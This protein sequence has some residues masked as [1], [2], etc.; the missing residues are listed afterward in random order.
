VHN[1]S[2]RST[3]Y[4]YALLALI[5][6]PV[7][8]HFVSPN[9]MTRWATAAAIVENRTFEI[10]SLLPLLG[11]NAFEDASEVGGR[12]YSNKAP[13]A[14]LIGL[15]AYAVARLITGP[16]S[17]ATMRMTAN[18]MRL[19]AATLPLLLL[20][21]T[22]KRA[23]KRLAA[24]NERIDVTVLALL[25][26]TPLFAYGLL[27][28][29]HALTA[30]ALFSAWAML[31]VEPHDYAAGALI[32]LATISEYPCAIAGIVLIACAWRRAPRIVAGG[33]PFALGLAI[34][35]KLLFG[36]IFALSS[37]NERN[38]QFRSMAR[39]GL[40]GIG[41]PD[42]MTLLRLL[43]DPSR[44][45]FVFAPIL[46]V[47]LVALPRARR[48]L[49][50]EA[51][52]ALALVP[53]ALIIFY[54][55][56]P[57]WHG[58]WSV[59]PRY[60]VPAIPFLLFP[61]IFGVAS[62]IE[63]IALGASVAAVVPIALTFPFPDRSFAAPWSTLSLPLLRDGLVAP[64]L[65]HLVARPLAIAIPFA[66]VIAALV[67]TAKRNAVW[68]ALGIILMFAL[69]A[70]AP[71]PSL[72]TRLRIGYIEEV[73]FEQPDA[74]SRAVGGLPVPPRAIARAQHEETLPPT[75]WPF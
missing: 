61:L 40:F 39:E 63:W 25:F 75:S 22:M 69:G 34:Y 41:L 54:S 28:F 60:L 68:I 35:N 65:L 6:I 37:G 24:Q 64:N 31:F 4:L 29:S 7:F 18:A 36:S 42:P 12:V 10:T 14:A 57:N 49:P 32:G 50:T 62:I 9:E 15:P 53:I 55:G 27:N 74:M 1:A 38:A 66:I 58:G 20:A 23:A 51:F 5:V 26:G 73:Y 52:L 21:W 43:V 72:T 70:L 67:L 19:L 3:P 13:G 56:Y 71:A 33:L 47:A 30:A 17:A 2:V 46:I 48:A 8:P 59:G 11:G 45:L 16:P 44:G